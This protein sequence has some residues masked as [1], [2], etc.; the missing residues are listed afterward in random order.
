MLAMHGAGRVLI[1]AHR[2][3]YGAGHD[4]SVAGVRYAAEVGADAVEFD[5]RRCSDGVFVCHHDDSIVLPTGDRVPVDALSSRELRAHQPLVPLLPD[6]VQAVAAAGV[7]A[8]VDLKFATPAEVLAAG[9]AWEVTAAELC[10]AHLDPARIILTTSHEPAVGALRRWVD[11][12]GHRSLVGLTVGQSTSLLGWR[13]ATRARLRE[14]FPGR[15]FRESGATLLVAHHALARVRLIRWA[16][17]RGVPVLVWTVD[18][19]RSMRRLLRDPR[20]WM[21]TTNW[22]ARAAAV[23]RNLDTVRASTR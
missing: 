2:C 5:V 12:H 6:L 17:R 14:L 7:R 9:E 4:N 19:P 21:I 23:R 16:H 13:E 15:R 11:E 3:G 1:S 20:V 22:P 10:A 8:H 18:G